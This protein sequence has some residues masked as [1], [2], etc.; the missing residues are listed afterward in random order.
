MWCFVSY[1]FLSFI[2]EEDGTQRGEAVSLAQVH[3][4]NQ[5]KNRAH[6]SSS[7]FSLPI[8]Y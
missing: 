7:L 8:L 6:L 2:D 4:S 3:T 1:Y 5:Q